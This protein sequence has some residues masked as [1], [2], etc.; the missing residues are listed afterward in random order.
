[1]GDKKMS[2]QSRTKKPRQPGPGT[3][4]VPRHEQQYALI[5]D[6]LV[7]VGHAYRLLRAVPR[8]VVRIDVNSWA[9]L[10]GL[11]GNP[12][13]PIAVGP[14]FD[15]VHALTTDLTRPLILATFRVA[16]RSFAEL[17]VDGAHRLYHAFVEG[18]ETLPGHILSAAETEVIT[19]SAV[20]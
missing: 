14:L 18:Y 13:S 4:L 3:G 2:R 9:G 12:D 20:M 19:R 15:P 1:M 16:E 5:G 11:D 6:L 7:D 17:I 10:Y 8:S